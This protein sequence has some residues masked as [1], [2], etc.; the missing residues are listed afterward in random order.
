MKKRRFRKPNATG[1]S[2]GG[3]QFVPLGYLML[4]SPAWRSLSGA[5]A[6]VFPEIRSRYNGGNNGKLSLSL[7]EAARLL[8]IGKATAAR[9]FAELEEKGFLTL[10]RR[11]RWYGRLASEY[12]TTDRPLNG[13][14]AT[15]A[16][17][18]WTPEKQSPG[19]RTDHIHALTG[20]P[21]NRGMGDGSAMEPV[22]P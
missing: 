22:K 2:E 15:N 21:R 10:T 3:E 18:N 9:A 12:A 11:G 8:G 5:A 13:H 1:R 16:W 4:Q 20:P 7:D 19:S 6:K 14:L 17:K